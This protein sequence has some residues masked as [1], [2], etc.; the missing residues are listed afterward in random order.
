MVDS[1]ALRNLKTNRKDNVLST[2]N[3]KIIKTHTLTTNHQI[4][5]KNKRLQKGCKWDAKSLKKYH[6]NKLKNKKLICIICRQFHYCFASTAFDFDLLLSKRITRGKSSM[7]SRAN[8][9]NAST[10]A[11]RLACL[12]RV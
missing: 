7:A 4:P 8:V 1:E 12:T 5:P 6:K 2:K 11:K 9:L 10:K 3:P